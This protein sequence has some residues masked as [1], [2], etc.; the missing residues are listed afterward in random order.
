MD[1]DNNSNIIFSFI[2]WCNEVNKKT[3]VKSDKVWTAFK[4]GSNYY[5]AWGARGKK[6]SFKNHGPAV[7]L[8]AWR[9]S[10]IPDTLQVVLRDKKKKYKE[11]DAFQLF[12]IFPFF[13]QEV[14]QQLVFKMLA[15][16]IM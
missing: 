10:E 15:N 14:D 4:A 13:E 2:G 6:L 12:A 5:A 3:G 9:Y 16:K 11:V 7:A 1:E 8:S